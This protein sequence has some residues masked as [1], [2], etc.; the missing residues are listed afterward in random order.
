MGATGKD[1]DDAIRALMDM[2]EYGWIWI[3]MNVV[4]DAREGNENEPDVK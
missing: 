2:D 1:G 3:N 4:G